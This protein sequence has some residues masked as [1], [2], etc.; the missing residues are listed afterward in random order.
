MVQRL[1]DTVTSS[2]GFQKASAFLGGTSHVVRNGTA[3][4][5]T[6]VQ[7]AGAS[8]DPNKPVKE[9]TI[10]P[11][12]NSEPYFQSIVKNPLEQY[13]SFTQVWTLACLEPAQFNNPESYRKE[14]ALKNI[15]LSSAGRFDAERVK[16]ASGSPEFFIDDVEIV[17]VISPT[18]NVGN[19][20]AISLNFKVYEPFSMG[21]FLQSLQT[22]ARLSRY[23]NYISAPFVLKLEYLGYNDL[24]QVLSPTNNPYVSPK[25]FVLQLTRANFTVNEGGSQYEVTAVPYNHQAFNDVTTTVYKDISLESG[26]TGTV[27][28][29]LSLGEK[30]LVAALNQIEQ[31][32]VKNGRIRVPDQYDIQFPSEA[33]RFTR[34]AESSSGNNP[35]SAD[36][37]SP[38]SKSIG[39]GGIV[40]TTVDLD[41]NPIGAA[42]FGFSQATG[43][44]YPFLKEDEALNEAGVFEKNGLRIDPQNRQFQ[45]SQGQSILKIIERIITSSTH[46]TDAQKP[47]N[48]I[49]GFILYYRV[50]VQTELLEFDDLIGDY[51]KKITFRIVPYFVHESIFMNPNSVPSGYKELENRVVKNYEYIYTGQNV[52]VLNFEIK[53]NNLFYVGMNPSPEDQNA[54]DQDLAT[55]GTSPDSANETRTAEGAS[56][57]AKFSNIGRPRPLP[58]PEL[59]KENNSGGSG[60]KTVAIKVAEAFHRAFIT[61]SSAD[62]VSVDLEIL[63][64]PYWLSDSGIG[65]YFSRPTGVLSQITE[66]GSMSKDAAEVYVYLTFRT[67]ADINEVTGLYNFPVVGNKSPFSG[68]YRVVKVESIFASGRF[69]QRLS[70]VRMI[71]Q[72]QDFIDTPTEIVQT[73]TLNDQNKLAVEIG[74]EKPKPISVIDDEEG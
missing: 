20:Q 47:E 36:P 43:G 16:T 60:E 49:D 37:N 50:D 9:D 59:L 22:A 57:G 38:K 63:G 11:I 45:F 52:D 61:G 42:N 30:S 35:A 21:L 12:K 58:D 10:N 62:L 41:I 31:N 70:C 27:A 17:S 39:G 53:I 65:N 51:A 33:S 69:T 3:T 40:E 8:V 29:V 6:N 48:K 34:A 28:E 7:N 24:G 68:I 64:D 5:V 55:S 4:V 32:L 73:L 1:I 44:K 2:E 18:Q 13:A 72:S 25:Y 15:V 71:G 66:D 26:E 46:A 54:T 74:D 19:S 14:G 56:P 67:A 23:P